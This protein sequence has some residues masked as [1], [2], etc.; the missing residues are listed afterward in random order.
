[1]D[2]GELYRQ[3]VDLLLGDLEARLKGHQESATGARKRLEYP[4]YC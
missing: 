1:M 2:S 4:P 3:E